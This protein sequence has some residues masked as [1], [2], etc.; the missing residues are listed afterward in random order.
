MRAQELRNYATQEL[1][2]K[3]T[4]IFPYYYFT[5]SVKIFTFCTK[6]TKKPLIR[7]IT[8]TFYFALYLKLSVLA[9]F[10]FENGRND[11]FY[12]HLILKMAETV[13]FI[14]I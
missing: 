13:R 14:A 2:C 10:D 12:P 11:S 6:Q 3:V 4:M 8:E 1:D 7:P 5:K 9:P